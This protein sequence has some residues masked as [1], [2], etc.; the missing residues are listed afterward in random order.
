MSQISGQT[1]TQKT[2]RTR[3]VK[4]WSPGRDDF[5]PRSMIFGVLLAAIVWPL[6]VFLLW[7][8]TRHLG[9]ETIDPSLKVA[10]AKPV[11]NIEMSPD[12]FIMP[13]KP[14]QAPPK[15][16]ETN[17]DAPENTPDKTSN[18]GARNQQA[19][20]EKPNPDAHGDRAATEGKKDWESN[21]VVSGQLTPPAETPPPEPPPT[22]EVAAALEKAA[23]A[24]KAENPLPGF[25]KL[26]G[27][28]PN[29]FGMNKAEHT[30]NATKTD[31]KVE[32]V[33]DAPT[34]VGQMSPAQPQIDPR[35]PQPRQHIEQQRVRP[36]IFAENKVGTSNIG[37]AGIDSRWSNYGA[38]LQRLIDAVQ[39]Q[40]DR[41][42]DESR[43]MPPTGTVVTVKFRMNKEGAISEI[44]SAESTG[45]KQAETICVTSITSRSP[46]GK[47]TDDMIAMLGDSQEMTWRFYYGTP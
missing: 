28:N 40:F 46:Y 5:D 6:L 12:E 25:E 35:K 47:W 20:Q 29:G 36:A 7:F 14:K 31:Q 3:P 21:Q 41:L 38:Y 30:D 15:F 19:A 37:L 26:E 45:G 32:G 8:G 44:I 24:R 33:K 27:T 43:I 42:N 34:T 17:P 39:G 22:P 13:R 23:E 9:K 18:F 1:P 4:K 2:P 10:R 16:V 11:F